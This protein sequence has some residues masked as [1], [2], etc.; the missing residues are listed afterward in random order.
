[1]QKLNRAGI[2]YGAAFC[3]TVA[4]AV[5]LIVLV[6]F[7][8]QD[9]ISANVKRSAE[10]MHQEGSYP[11]VGDH[12][13][14]A[15]LDSFTDAIMLMA[16]QRTNSEQLESVLTNPMVAY[17]GAEEYVDYLYRYTQGETPS[18]EWSYNRYWMG[19]RVI[20]RL[21]L[22]FLDYYQ[23]RRYLAFALFGLFFVLLCT[24][25][26]RIGTKQSIAFAFSI[27]LI[28]PY[29]ICNSLQLSCCFLIAFVSMLAVPWIRDNPRYEKLFFMEIGMLT[30]YFDFYT[31]PIITFGF[32][33]MYLYLLYEAKGEKY[34]A[35]WMLTNLLVWFGAYVLMW[36]SKM[37]LTE[38][39]T[40]EEAFTIGFGKLGSWLGFGSQVKEAGFYSPIVALV[41]VAAAVAADVKGAVVIVIAVVILACLALWAWKTGRVN[42]TQC[43]KCYLP[44]LIAGLPVLWFI[45]ACEPT[46]SHYWF[47]YRSIAVSYWAIGAYASLVITG[48][49]GINCNET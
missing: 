17:D 29:V 7:L 46:A 20:L 16:S 15:Q 12:S 40:K 34:T 10:M 30:M 35:K 33:A 38:L 5:L 1:M 47:Q 28:R 21:A 22:V 44:L 39:F 32:P 6:S 4:A 48:R 11:R 13:A 43:A 42:K 26:E 19:F 3:L 36:I 25:V 2:R 49:R 31:V 41:R 37:V 23:I 8:P 24:M 14:S 27:L 9:R 45:V 18:E